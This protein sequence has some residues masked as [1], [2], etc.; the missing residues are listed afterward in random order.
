MR[1]LERIRGKQNGRNNRPEAVLAKYVD[2]SKINAFGNRVSEWECMK[3][4]SNS[5]L[6][7][8]YGCKMCQPFEVGAKLTGRKY[9]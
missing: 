8:E 7:M 1:K 3:C 5:L 9:K 6:A 2:M 4:H